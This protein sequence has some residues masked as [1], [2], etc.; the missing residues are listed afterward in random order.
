MSGN[1]LLIY[2]CNFHVLSHLLLIY[3]CKLHW[4]IPCARSTTDWIAA[5]SPADVNISTSVPVKYGY[6]N[7]NSS[8]MSIDPNVRG[9]GSLSFNFTNLRSDIAIYYFTG[10]TTHPVL[11]DRYAENITFVEVNEPLRPRI[12]KFLMIYI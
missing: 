6:C 2:I 12:G 9:K 10:S 5:Y 8:Y 4:D 1:F 11:R 7:S 3:I